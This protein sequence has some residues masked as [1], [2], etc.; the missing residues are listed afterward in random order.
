MLKVL[1]K[2]N[3]PIALAIRRRNAFFKNEDIGYQSAFLANVRN[4]L[5]PYHAQILENYPSE[6][7]ID[8]IYKEVYDEMNELYIDEHWSI[9]NADYLE[10]M[11]GIL[12]AIHGRVRNYELVYD[13]KLEENKKKFLENDPN[14]FPIYDLT[15]KNKEP[16]YKTIWELDKEFNDYIEENVGFNLKVKKS[17]I[18]HPGKL[19]SYYRF[20]KRDFSIMQK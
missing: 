7:D 11:Y 3:S 5:L 17:R 15:S 20:W 18:E 16:D 9:A 8:K 12:S 14:T 2:L 1:E 4:R 10:Q 13:L 6:N 19:L